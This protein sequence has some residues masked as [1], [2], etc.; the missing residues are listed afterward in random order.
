MIIDDFKAYSENCFRDCQPPCAC[1]CPL[2]LDVRAVMD[3]VQRK[4]FNAAYRLYRNQVL[5]PAIVSRICDQPCRQHCVRSRADESIFLRQIEEATVVNAKNTDPIQYNVPAKPFTI[6]IIGAGL[7][8]LSCALKMA[9]RNYSVKLYEK[10]D[11]PGGR[12]GNILEP[13]IFLTEI[14]KQFAN[15]EYEFMPATLINSLEGLK[16][17]AIYIATGR[18]GHDFGL[19]EGLNNNSLGTNKP[20]IFM[21]G[22]LLGASP[23]ESI[24][25]GIRASYSIEKFFKVGAMDGVPETYTRA[26][27]KSSFYNLPFDKK[28]SNIG[29][30]ADLSAQEAIEE[31]SRCLLCNCSI[32]HDNCELMQQAKTFPPKMTTDVISSLG[33][34]ENVTQRVGLRMANA[35]N[36]CGLCKEICPENVDMEI[37]LLEARRSLHSDG[38]MPP[39]YREY[40]LREMGLANSEAFLSYRPDGVLDAEFLFFPGCQLGASNPDYVIQAYDYILSLSPKTM[41]LQAC[42][43]IPAD[44]AGD[45]ALRDGALEQIKSQWES[46]GRPTVILACP[47]CHKTFKKYLPEISVVSL[48]EVMAK[49]FVWPLNQT[50]EVVSVYDPCA[51]RDDQR[52]RES[53]RMLVKVSGLQV[54]E[55]EKPIKCCGYG[56]HIQAVN[57][58]LYQEIVD[59]RIGH[60]GNEYITYCANCRDVFAASGK[61]A[62]HI[63]DVLFTGLSGN[64]KPPSLS[65]RRH[66]RIAVKRYFL[67]KNGVNFEPSKDEFNMNLNISDFLIEKMNGQL[68]TEEDVKAVIEHCQSTGEK[69]YNPKT[70]CN[71]GFK[72]IGCITYWVEYLGDNGNYELSNVYSHR[73]TIE[74]N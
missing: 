46:S 18:N 31:S 53:V 71:V 32:C 67:E 48:Y 27:I 52:L 6:A 39:G 33:P 30:K 42:C 36:L 64:R 11:K 28:S 74:K 44:W 55:F 69:A 47:T 12:L 9:A 24:E 13:E 70:G 5:F 49:N 68:I 73:M 38:V 4:N 7:S 40:W 22:G 34:K 26:E 8:G 60:N 45:V 56:G 37:C 58:K 54:E 35:C 43:S 21:G 50:A 66:N 17:D 16:A 14:E 1:V 57:K 72:Q 2:G 10:N 65:Q 3:K 25:H 61:A 51:S 63:L 59:D 20:G 15:V 62:R 23:I 41:L 29:G 19:K